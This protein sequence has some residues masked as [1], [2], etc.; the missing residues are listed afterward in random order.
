MRVHYLQHVAFEGLGSIEDY[1]ITKKCSLTSTKLYDGEPLP[2]V[3]DIDWLII[4]GGPM[5]VSDTED[6]PW[7]TAELAFIRSAIDGGKVVL[8]ICLGAQ[9]IAASLGSRVLRNEFP[10][11]GWFPLEPPA[12]E[13]SSVLGDIFRQSCEVFHWHG[14]TFELPADAR[15]LASSRGCAHQAFSLDDRVFGFQF[16]LETT[17][18]SAAKLLE[19]CSDDIDGSR[20]TQRADE[21]MR[22]EQ[23]FHD[24]N[25]IMTTVLQRIEH[26]NF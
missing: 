8:G 26:D 14:D 12:S 5:G 22:D 11:I 9:L 18:S 20:Y 16:H 13:H 10:E 17:P 23:R 7:L 21:I 3:D 24:I 4:M 6:Y 15:L 1:F 25:S 2:A 19:Q